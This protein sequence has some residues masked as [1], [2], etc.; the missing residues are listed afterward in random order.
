MQ[1]HF[2]LH[3]S[4][5]LSFWYCYTYWIYILNASCWFEMRWTTNVQ[6]NKGTHGK[7][8]APSFFY[9]IEIE[10][11]GWSTIELIWLCVKWHA[12][13]HIGLVFFSLSPPLLSLFHFDSY[14]VTRTTFID[15][16]INDV[17]LVEQIWTMGHSEYGNIFHTSYS[18]GK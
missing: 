7:V 4:E 5:F 14:V 2:N 11:C 13:L 18:R 8:L 1:K 9:V 17:T 6:H 15:E 10:I 3:H 16:Q 12:D